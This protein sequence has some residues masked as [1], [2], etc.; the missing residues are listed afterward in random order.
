MIRLI[1][2]QLLAQAHFVFTQWADPTADRRH[3]LTDVEMQA[4]H[5][6]RVDLPAAGREHL[7]DRLEG[8]KHDAVCHADQ[9]APPHSLDHLRVKQLRQWHPARLGG[10]ASSLTARELHPV[11]IVGEQGRHVLSQ[12]VGHKERRTIGCQH[13]RDV[14]DEALRY[15]QG[16]L[17]AVPSA[18]VRL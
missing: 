17:A 15:R 14:V 10:R 7:L 5:E 16:A 13:L 3:M 1:Q 11:P 9:T 12:S 4:L 18:V 6:G 8:A 2:G